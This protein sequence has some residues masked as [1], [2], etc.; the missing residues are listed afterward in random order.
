MS[1]TRP[2]RTRSGA[3]AQAGVRVNVQT[4]MPGFADPIFR[5][6][7][8]EVTLEGASEESVTLIAEAF[9]AARNGEVGD[10]ARIRRPGRG[11]NSSA[12]TSSLT[13]YRR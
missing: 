5:L 10:A 12:L 1:V 11:R 3:L 4:D 2:R 6:G 13:S 9:A 7:S 8:A